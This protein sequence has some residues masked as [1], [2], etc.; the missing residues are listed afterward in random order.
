MSKGTRYKTYLLLYELINHIEHKGKRLAYLIDTNLVDL[1]LLSLTKEEIEDILNE[2]TDEDYKELAR[3]FLDFNTI[4]KIFY[5]LYY[6]KPILIP[7]RESLTYILQIAQDLDFTTYNGDAIVPDYHT[8]IYY[9]FKI[10]G[11]DLIVRFDTIN[12]YIRFSSKTPKDVELLNDLEG[13]SIFYKPE[14]V[15]E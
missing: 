11:N 5:D 6:H 9:P 13:V 8:T 3:A 1:L 2:G 4:Y 7:N 14:D 10:G 12:K 15:E